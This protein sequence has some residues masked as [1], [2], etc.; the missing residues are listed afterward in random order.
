MKLK[1]GE[2][3]LVLFSLAYIA[4]F[5]AYY[6][7]VRNF[8]FLWYVAVL[9][10]FF[11][12]IIATIRKSNFTYPILWGLSLWGLL[13]MAGGGVV[14]GGDV[15]YAYPV[16]PVAGEGDFLIFKYDQLV[17]AFGFGVTTLVV[18]HLI[19]PYLA[20]ETR[21]GIVYLFLV[22][23]GAGFGAFNEIVEFVAVLLFPET[24]VGGYANTMLDTV[25]NTVGATG[26]VIFI[27]TQRMRKHSRL[28]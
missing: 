28:T 9:V 15:L 16:L 18:H 11:A 2:W 3:F 17:H 27:H 6:V 5:G 24:G 25:F 4:G 10:F 19:R 13:H 1:R 12:L 23:A 22:A 14:V 20:T 7:A 8:E 26:A 21:W